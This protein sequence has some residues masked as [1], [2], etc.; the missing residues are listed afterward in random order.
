LSLPTS[1][2]CKKIDT[3]PQC[4]NI[5]T[6]KNYIKNINRKGSNIGHLDHN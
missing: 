4:L 6:L 2:S 1:Q 5:I 3:N